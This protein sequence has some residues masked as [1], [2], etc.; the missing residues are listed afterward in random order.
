[1]SNKNQPPS[2]YCCA[3]LTGSTF[4]THVQTRDLLIS[5]NGISLIR[6]F[7]TLQPQAFFNQITQKIKNAK[8]PKRVRFLRLI[9]A[10][11][12][13][14]L[15]TDREFVV[16]LSAYETS[17][18][19]DPQPARILKF[20]AEKAQVGKIFDPNRS[21][22]FEVVFSY[23][24]SLGIRIWPF[25]LLF[26]KETLAAPIELLRTIDEN[27]EDEPSEMDAEEEGVSLSDETLSVADSVSDLASIPVIDAHRNNSLLRIDTDRSAPFTPTEMGS[28]RIGSPRCSYHASVPHSPSSI[29]SSEN[30][31]DI[32]GSI[33]IFKGDRNQEDDLLSDDFDAPA[34]V[35]SSPELKSASDKPANTMLPLLAFPKVGNST[36]Q[37]STP[38]ES[39]L[40]S[41]ST[42]G[43]STSQSLSSSITS[44]GNLI[45][46]FSPRKKTE[47]VPPAVVDQEKAPE[48]D[49]V[50]Q[51]LVAQDS[52]PFASA[53]HS[54]S[55]LSSVTTMER[56][57]IPA[58]S[59]TK[60]KKEKSKS[61]LSPSIKAIATSFMA[62][63]RSPSRSP[64]PS[65]TRSA[66][67]S[68]AEAVEWPDVD[69]PFHE[70]PL[71][72]GTVSQQENPLHGNNHVGPIEIK[73]G[74]GFIHPTDENVTES[75]SCTPPRIINN[76]KQDVQEGVIVKIT[77]RS[78]ERR[79][80]KEC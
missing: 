43:E 10:E 18:I 60:V 9:R 50:D 6:E 63:L 79:V 67:R 77:D 49:S 33:G 42:P 39:T 23:Q 26:R 35:F 47:H 16:Q 27:D 28:P 38:G 54:V 78:E 76:Q 3:C 25:Q 34:Q 20:S 1:M 41:L 2:V 52:I 59:P 21:S 74:Y 14:S 72:V 57:I 8:S 19:L 58:P 4:T 30:V 31:A 65:P 11:D 75:V 51:H 56:L 45:L 24:Q 66:A 13:S 64:S 61:S 22:L 32:F 12:D 68:P 48:Q 5:I 15:Q 80:G 55:P 29:I 46:K 71:D 44:V 17:I 70:Q 36:D 40:Q 69:V 37:D 73:N 53:T 7:G 62:V